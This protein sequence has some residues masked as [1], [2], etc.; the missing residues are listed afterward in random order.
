MIKN[1]YF[2]CS[3]SSKCLGYLSWQLL[4]LL[5]PLPSCGG[6]MD[7]LLIFYFHFKIFLR[8]RVQQDKRWIDFQ[9]SSPSPHVS[10]SRLFLGLARRHCFC[11][12]SKIN[13]SMC[14]VDRCKETPRSCSRPL[15]LSS[16]LRF[17]PLSPKSVIKTAWLSQEML[18]VFLFFLRHQGP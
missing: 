12:L 9:M 16:D 2:T 3:V 11:L 10:P 7:W 14:Q 8:S 4:P 6:F 5:S 17:F 15:Y 1:K 18:M 13:K